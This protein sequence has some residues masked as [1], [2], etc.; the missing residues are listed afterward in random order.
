[1]ATGLMGYWARFR[2]QPFEQPYTSVAGTEN[3]EMEIS[4][5]VQM[6][7]HGSG[8]AQVNGQQDAR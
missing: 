6:R 2:N 7:W 4:V 5:Q 8:S 3:C 1:M